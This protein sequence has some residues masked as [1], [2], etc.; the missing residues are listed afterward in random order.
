MHIDQVITHIELMVKG[1]FHAD[2]FLSGPDFGFGRIAGL[3]MGRIPGL[4]MGCITGLSHGGISGP[5]FGQGRQLH[6]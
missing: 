5:G 2:L 1:V 3:G 4:R 6:A